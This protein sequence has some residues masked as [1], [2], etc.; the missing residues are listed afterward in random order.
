MGRMIINSFWRRFGARG[1]GRIRVGKRIASTT[2]EGGTF[3]GMKGFG[4]TTQGGAGGRSYIVTT[5]DDD[6]AGS[7]REALRYDGPQVITFG[8]GGI[9]W[10]LSLLTVRNPFVTIDGS[11]APS[12]VVLKGEKLRVQTHDVLIA[13]IRMRPGDV[14]PSE[15]FGDRDACSVGNHSVAGNVYNV[16]LYHCSLYWSVDE[17]LTA[18]EAH[19]FTFQNCIIAEA[20]YDSVHPEK[21]NPGATTPHSMSML[22]RSAVG[23]S[24]AYNGS[25]HGNLLANGNQRNPQFAVCTNIDFRNNLVYN[26]REEPLAIEAAGFKQINVVAN[27]YKPGPDTVFPAV[28]NPTSWFRVA[29]SATGARVHISGNTGPL[30]GDFITDPNFDNWLFLRL[31]S[32]LT[33]PDEPV[34][35]MAEPFECPAID[36]LSAA[37]TYQFVLDNAGATLPVRDAHDLRIIAQVTND[38]GLIIDSQDDVGGW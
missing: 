28:G 31:D 37:Q 33:P 10:N 7:L 29:N 23:N 21:G 5:T 24:P 20:L 17:G 35:H 9:I 30:D 32:G 2:T 25:V 13:H 11:T 4:T 34:H 26:W 36:Q 16:V 27:Y 38:T 1:L 15:D 6:G 14:P 12:P 19:D 18:D 8:V 22:F 3:A